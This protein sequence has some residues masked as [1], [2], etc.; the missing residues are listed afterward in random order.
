MTTEEDTLPTA[1]VATEEKVAARVHAS[2]GGLPLTKVGT[3]MPK[4][5]ILIYAPP[6]MGKTRL[7]ASA[8]DVP[9]MRE[10]LYIDIE[11]GTETIRELWP[12]IQAVRVKDEHD[13]AGRITRSAWSQCWDIYEG[14]KKGEI[15]VNTVAVDNITEMYGLAMADTMAD[16]LSKTTVER[17]PDIPSVR[18]YGKTST[19]VR[20]WIRLMRDLDV[21]LI[22]TAHENALTDDNGN[23][24]EYVP[25]LSGKLAHE[26]AGYVDIVMYLYTKTDKEDGLQ[27]KGLTQPANKH[28]AKDRSGKLPQVLTNPTMKMI[29]ELRKG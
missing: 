21:N 4:M 3:T 20:R 11:G 22:L 28:V 27:R 25:G 23:V 24:R 12:D 1:T 17:D 13:K 29:Y 19:Q 18:E 9:E 6:G 8:Q 10:L 26:V 7:A 16:M 2:I 14:L 5:K 15:D